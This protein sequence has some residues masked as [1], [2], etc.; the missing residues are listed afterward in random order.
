MSEPITA[1]Q[2]AVYRMRAKGGSA[3][4]K[5]MSVVVLEADQRRGVARV[6]FADGRKV[7]VQL[8]ELSHV[9]EPKPKAD[10]KPL[11]L[12][13][14]P[15]SA[16]IGEQL[17]IKGAVAAPPK[18]APA[19]DP[20]RNLS[21]ERFMLIRKLRGLSRHAAGAIMGIGD[22]AVAQ[23]E[24]NTRN[25]RSATIKQYAA[26]YQVP[27]DFLCP[28]VVLPTELP[29]WEGTK[30]SNEKVRQK[31][32]R[33]P[34]TQIVQAGNVSP[35]YDQWL[36]QTLAAHEKLEQERD[37]LQKTIADTERSLNEQRSLLAARNVQIKQLEKALA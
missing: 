29:P 27:E 4:T 8:T 2:P 5:S 22:G 16:S 11:R 31:P 18:Q 25:P 3:A 17:Q 6:K 28:D 32:G 20:K 35:V 36:E 1:G 12:V 30:P 15:L 21:G 14:A 37:Q 19:P 7:N 13:T 34:A 9:E 33:K 10:D 24:T 23:V 26:A